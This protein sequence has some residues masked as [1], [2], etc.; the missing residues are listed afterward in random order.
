MPIE[1]KTWIIK[2]AIFFEV[3]IEAETAENAHTTLETMKVCD[4]IEDAYSDIEYH[5]TTVV[6]P[7]SEYHWTTVKPE[8]D[9]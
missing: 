8:S 6:K 1:T 7:G 5:W 2:G 9:Q 4:W 3:E